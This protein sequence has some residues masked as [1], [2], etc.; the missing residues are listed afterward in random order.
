M[1]SSEHGGWVPKKK[2]PREGGPAGSQIVF[3]AYVE[4][5]CSVTSSALNSQSQPKALARLKRKERRLCLSIGNGESRRIRGPE[6]L[7][8]LLS[9]NVTCHK[10]HTRATLAVREGAKEPRL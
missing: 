8:W 9:D 4:K 5:S 6:I 3:T 2:V 1:V 7:L 10:D